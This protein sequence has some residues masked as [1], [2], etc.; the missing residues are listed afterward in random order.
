L[1]LLTA[2]SLVCALALAWFQVRARLALGDPVHVPDTPLI[3][4][5]PAGWVGDPRDAGAFVK[6]VRKMVWG[7]EQWAA[8]RKIEFRYN[9]YFSQLTR[10][11][12]AASLSP[13][14]SAEIAGWPGVQWILTRRG[15]RWEEQT[16]FRW[17]S[18][19]WGG[20]L[21]VEYTPLGEASDGDARLLDAVCK[22]VQ[23]DGANLVHGE[24]ETLAYAGVSFDSAQD[25]K[26]LG[27]DNMGG[28]GF[29]LQ[30]GEEDPPRWGLA[31]FRR[32]M[33]GGLPARV[34]ENEAMNAPGAFLIPVESLRGDRAYVAVS[35]CRDNTP[36]GSAIV[37]IWLVAESRTRIAVIYALASPRHARLADDAAE[38][39]VNRVEFVT[40]FPP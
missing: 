40:D 16:L 25:W 39:L 6:P 22:A 34:L 33:R 23:L 5:P 19:P 14:A 26:I 24:K 20:Q 18:A 37:S 36:G 12:Q 3:V 11:F 29:C 10:L 27:P 21:S 31:L 15:Q 4:R 38:K 13:G 9:D 1:I 2:G 28:P 17:V 8:E 7:R 30:D 35:R 32:A